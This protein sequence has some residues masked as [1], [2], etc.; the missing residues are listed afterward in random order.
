[1]RTLKLMRLVGA[2]TLLASA[3]VIGAI[4]AYAQTMPPA[5]SMP[6]TN[7]DSTA[8][9]ARPPKA[10]MGQLPGSPATP[11][12]GTAAGAAG[13]PAGELKAAGPPP[14]AGQV[15]MTSDGQRAG[16]VAGVKAAPDGRVQEIHVKTGGM[17]GF[18]TR[19]VAIPAGSFAV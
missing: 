14:I 8:P 5:P 2:V 19:T 12:P 18:G 1:M 7:D 10:P 16:E 15:V 17:L 11:A 3:P 4:A 13:S 6:S 9:P